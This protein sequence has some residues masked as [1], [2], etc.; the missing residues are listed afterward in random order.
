LEWLTNCHTSSRFGVIPRWIAL[1][2][3]KIFSRSGHL[4]TS[5]TMVGTLTTQRTTFHYQKLP[6]ARKLIMGS[7]MGF[8]HP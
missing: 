4:H 6:F 8:K 2:S 3:I 1:C 7:S 5:W